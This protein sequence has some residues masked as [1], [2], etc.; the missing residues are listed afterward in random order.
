MPERMV[1]TEMLPP[2]RLMSSLSSKK[3]QPDR[4][5]I[6]CICVMEWEIVV[7]CIH[8]AFYFLTT[9]WR[10]IDCICM[11]WSATFAR[12]LATISRVCGVASL[13]VLGHLTFEN[14]A[15]LSRIWRAAGR[16]FHP[17][18]VSFLSHAQ[19]FRLHTSCIGY[20]LSRPLGMHPLGDTAPAKEH[21]S[22]L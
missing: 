4:E 7:I 14:F 9:K 12:P 10:K 3:T 21:A 20:L 19:T 8:V 2:T 15:A 18:V 17:L 6:I 16:V 13:A 22:G 1:G 11:T 5:V